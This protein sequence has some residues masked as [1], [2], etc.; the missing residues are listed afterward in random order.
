MAGQQ[1]TDDLI[2]MTQGVPTEAGGERDA[3]YEMAKSTLRLW[4]ISGT[5]EVEL[6]RE[7]MNFIHET[8]RVPRA[9]FAPSRIERIDR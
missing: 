3:M 9:E 4:P 1:T 2:H 5:T 8:L 7:A 6:R